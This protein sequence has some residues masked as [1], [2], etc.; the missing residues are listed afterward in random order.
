MDA[1]VYLFS[2]GFSG[3]DA[4]RAALLLLFGALF[5]TKR[6]PPWRMTMLLLLIDTAWPYVG[7]AQ[8]G[9][10]P[11]AIS[12]AIR[13]ALQFHE[14]AVVGFLVRASGFYVFLRGTFSIRRKL[15]NAFPE[16]KSKPGLLPF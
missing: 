6:F 9:A 4:A 7:M 13:G 3:T 2:L 10:G 5:V 8:A 1:L 11:Q 15:Q 14:D 16:D 12:T